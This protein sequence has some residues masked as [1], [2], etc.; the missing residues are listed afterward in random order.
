MTKYYVYRGV[1]YTKDGQTKTTVANRQLERVYRGATR[2]ELP[3][4]KHVISDH[5]YRG[6]HY[7]A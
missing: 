2:F 4:F 5:I 1:T 7:M 6:A 3:N